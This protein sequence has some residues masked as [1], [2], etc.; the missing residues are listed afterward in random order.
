MYKKF[1]RKYLVWIPV[2]GLAF[3]KPKNNEDG[4]DDNIRL[5]FW[6]QFICLLLL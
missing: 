6:Y 2:L 3:L 4:L 1:M 5:Y